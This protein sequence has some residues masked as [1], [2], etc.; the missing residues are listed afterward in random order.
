MTLHFILKLPWF[1]NMIS[2]RVLGWW[3]L[4]QELA[5]LN[6]FF[7]IASKNLR[8][9]NT[10]GAQEPRCNFLVLNVYSMSFSLLCKKVQATFLWSRGLIKNFTQYPFGAWTSFAV[11]E[12]INLFEQFE[13]LMIYLIHSLASVKLSRLKLILLFD[14]IKFFKLWIDEI[15]WVQIFWLLLPF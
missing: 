7:L 14:G 9:V 6:S 11:V 12:T 13:V 1:F 15:V 10:I 8:G 3:W 2:D 5:K 4:L